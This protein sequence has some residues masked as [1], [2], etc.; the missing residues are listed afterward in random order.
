MFGLQDSGVM[1]NSTDDWTIFYSVESYM[2]RK[3]RGKEESGFTPSVGFDPSKGGTEGV[4][5]GLGLSISKSA[6]FTNIDTK[7]TIIVAPHS[8]TKTGLNKI[9]FGQTHLTVIAKRPIV[10]KYNVPRPAELPEEEQKILMEGIVVKHIKDMRMLIVDTKNGLTMR[11]YRG[12][13]KAL[14]L[15]QAAKVEI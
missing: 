9:K 10:W 14:S 13:M 6:T 8:H 3:E 4:S 7:G 11:E 12:E 5:G 1:V 2:E 15:N